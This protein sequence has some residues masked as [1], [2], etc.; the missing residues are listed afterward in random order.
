MAT[1]SINGVLQAS[2]KYD[3]AGRQVV[4]ALSGG[5]TIHSVFDADGNR[6]A[7][8]DQTSGALIREYV[9]FDGAA[10][11]VIE[12]GVVYYIRSDHIG[13]PVFATNG[14]GVQV[15]TAS[16]LP[17]GGVRTATGTPITLRF[18]G[19]WFQSESGLHQNWMRDYNPTTGRYLQADPLGLVDGPSVYG[20]ARQSPGRYT[21]PTGEFVP[22]LAIVF[23]AVL[24]TP[25]VANAPGNCDE[26][27]PSDP[28][29]PY[30]NGILAG[31]TAGPF[32]GVGSRAAA[33]GQSADDIVSVVTRRTRTGDTAVKVTHRNGRVM[34]ISPRRVKGRIP[35]NHPN[36]PLGSKNDIK[37]DNPIPGTKGYKRLPT[38]DELDSLKGFE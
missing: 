31:I 32:V 1:F 7:E 24:L 23:I 20:Y 5:A 30:I 35:N 21:D 9:W 4:R 19:Q 37:F 28:A 33:A 34:D 14:A 36:A 12:G 10:V 22:L 15:W 26:V 29:A 8:Y 27:V 2:Y 38:K 17:F 6:I 3:F 11:A 16:Y 13:R 18:P 25:D